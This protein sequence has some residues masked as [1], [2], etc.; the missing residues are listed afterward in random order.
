MPGF[1]FGYRSSTRG[2]GGSMKSGSAVSVAIA[3]YKLEAP[4][5]ESLQRSTLIDEKFFAIYIIFRYPTFY[6]RFKEV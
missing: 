1:W 3:F 4:L 6:E 2:E 5:S